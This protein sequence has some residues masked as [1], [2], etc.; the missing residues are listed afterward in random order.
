MAP[1]NKWTN[2]HTSFPGRLNFAHIAMPGAVKKKDGSENPPKYR[3]NLIQ[4]MNP[5]TDKFIAEC[6]ELGLAYFGEKWKTSEVARRPYITGDKVLTAYAE[7]LKKQGEGKTP[8]ESMVK[9]YH[10]K[11][12]LMASGNAEKDAP[13]C[14]I[15]VP[16]EP[17][18]REM[19]RRPGVADDIKAIEEQFYDGCYCT[20]AVKGFC[21][22]QSAL[23]W[24]ISLCLFAIKFM[25][26]GEKIGAVDIDAAFGGAEEMPADA[27][28][29]E[30]DEAMV[31]EN[32]G[33]NI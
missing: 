14:Y 6:E 18:A 2:L 9:L 28:M 21:Y 7:K 16:G 17:K 20:L 30:I 8:S 10:E 29:D 11:I 24:G 3:A 33:E 22:E 1:V 12:Q 15:V 31:D 5:H 32:P 25:R 26:D 19:Y 13:R 4:K 27:Y 23:S